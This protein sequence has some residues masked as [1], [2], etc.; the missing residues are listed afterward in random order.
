MVFFIERSIIPFLYVVHKMKYC[1]LQVGFK[2]LKS[3]KM[4]DE[5]LH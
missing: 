2:I 1:H 3:A 5:T 4:C